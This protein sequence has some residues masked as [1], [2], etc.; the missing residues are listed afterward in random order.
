MRREVAHLSN[1]SAGTYG[2]VQSY[3]HVVNMCLQAAVEENQSL[4]VRTLESGE[5]R[6][7]AG[8]EFRARGYALESRSASELGDLS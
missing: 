2:R 8:D 4:R 7:S 5:A 6:P 1:S 3:R